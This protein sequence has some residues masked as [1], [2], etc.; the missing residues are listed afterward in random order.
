MPCQSKDA[1]SRPDNHRATMISTPNSLR[2][3]M[4]GGF[5]KRDSVTINFV[6][7]R[8]GRSIQS[9][10]NSRMRKS[11]LVG[12]DALWRDLFG[13]RSRFILSAVETRPHDAAYVCPI[14]Y[15]VYDYYFACVYPQPSPNAA[16]RYAAVE[17]FPSPT[18]PTLRSTSAEPQF[19]IDQLHYR[20]LS[21]CSIVLKLLYIHPLIV[22]QIPNPTQV[23]F[24]QCLD[25]YHS[26]FAW[27]RTG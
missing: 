20:E 2:P 19:S 9:P 12:F 23:S 16:R 22:D 3:M 8:Y 11:A 1:C 10:S 25:S 24:S 14:S 4:P 15:L 6:T 18:T 13:T 5:S 27:L 21:R 7:D 26:I 17:F